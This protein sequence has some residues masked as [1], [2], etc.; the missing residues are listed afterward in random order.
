MFPRAQRCRQVSL[1]LQIERREKG[2]PCYIGRFRSDDSDRLLEKISSTDIFFFW[3]EKYFAA[4][5][6]TVSFFSPFLFFLGTIL[7]VWTKQ[8]HFTGPIPVFFFF[9]FF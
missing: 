6:I 5:F 7:L 3:V 2:K 8:F 9:S 1:G 4:V